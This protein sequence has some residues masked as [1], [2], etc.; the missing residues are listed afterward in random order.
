MHSLE[1]RLWLAGVVA[2][3]LALRLWDLGQIFVFADE[4]LWAYYP[5][6]LHTQSILAW[7]L[8]ENPIAQLVRWKYG[9]YYMTLLYLYTGL[10]SALGIAANEF[11][12][13][14]PVALFGSAS[15]VLVYL[16][17]RELLPPNRPGLL[18]PLLVAVLPLHVGLSRTMEV[19]RIPASFLLLLTLYLFL[20]YFHAPSRRFA[21]YAS[22]SLALYLVSHL[23]SLGI[24]PLLVAA[25]LIA[26]NPGQG[27]GGV[28]WAERLSDLHRLLF[29]PAIVVLPGVTFFPNILV[30]LYTIQAGKVGGFLGYMLTRPKLPG[31]HLADVTSHTLVNVG[32]A[33]IGLCLLGFGYGLWRLSQG[34]RE[35]ILFCYAGI[36]LAPYVFVI[37]EEVTG[38]REYLIQGTIPLVMLG[39]NAL[40]G[41]FVWARARTARRGRGAVVVAAASVVGLLVLPTMFWTFR[42]VFHLQ[43]D[44]RFQLQRYTSEYVNEK[45]HIF[46][47]I[48]QDNGIKAAGYFVR[49]HVPPSKLVFTDMTPLHGAY[50]LGRAVFAIYDAKL[51]QILDYLRE[52]LSEVDYAIINAA[53]AAAFEAVLPPGS[54]LRRVIDITT[55]G[56]V[57]MIVYAVDPVPA[58]VLRTE[59]LNPLFDRKYGFVGKL[60][61]EWGEGVEIGPPVLGPRKEPR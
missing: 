11:F 32:P 16:I 49:E 33:L 55:L 22:G 31:F 45:H 21:L 30:L 61:T 8:M 23:E 39:A 25:G 14:L 35:G 1:T 47:S 34:E 59:E 46:G 19:N 51:P 5:F 38:T 4:A 27:W 54:P 29:R 40:E 37:S 42:L 20:R 12:M 44:G 58:R 56:E 10:L 57:V 2:G 18:A 41:L 60:V 9:Y 15:L 3:G 48:R 52:V 6:R 50:Y 43:P 7:P 24:L 13:L 28:G 53:N 17:G 36:Y 26:R